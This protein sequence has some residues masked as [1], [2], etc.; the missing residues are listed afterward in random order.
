MIKRSAPM[1]SGIAQIA[2]LYVVVQFENVASQC[3]FR[4]VAKPDFR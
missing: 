4:E 2:C 3:L 1:N